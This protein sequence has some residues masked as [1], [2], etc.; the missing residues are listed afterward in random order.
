M[1]ISIQDLLN[2]IPSDTEQVVSRTRTR[3]NAA[4]RQMLRQ[5]TGLRLSSGRGAEDENHDN[6]AIR[7]H[8]EAGVPAEMERMTFDDEKALA[9]LLL[10]WRTVLQLHQSSTLN[11]TDGLIRLL[12]K[13]LSSEGRFSGIEEKLKSTCDFT[14][15][16][17]GISLTFDLLEELHA[18]D[19][20]ILGQYRWTFVRNQTS[21]SI[22]LFW[23]VIGLVARSLGISV[24]GLTVKVLAHELAHAYTH[25][26]ADIDGHRWDTEDF[27][28]TDR[29]VKEG[30]AQ[31]YTRQLVGRIKDRMPEAE[32]AY[33]KLLPHQPAVYR[34]QEQWIEQG[35]SAEHIRLAMVLFRRSRSSTLEQFNGFLDQAKRDLGGRQGHSYESKSLDLL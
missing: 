25:L 3:F 21:G 6:Q 34:V 13:E 16:L 26:G 8:I 27:R 31:Y 10:P 4:V 9:I 33:R 15:T 11:I 12:P 28:K 5:E 14:K 23:G 1:P 35:A 18:I 29:A 2:Q 24:E 32:E 30:L 7:V 22:H 17:L 20:D 19:D